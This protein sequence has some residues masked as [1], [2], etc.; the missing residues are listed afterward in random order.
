MLLGTATTNLFAQDRAAPSADPTAVTLTRIDSPIVIDGVVDEAAW[1]NVEPFDVVMY[2]PT[3]EGD[4][5]E[6]TEI[7]VAYDNDYV[8]VSGKLFDSEPDGVRSYSL[9]RDRYSGDDTFAIIL[10]TFNDNENA[11]WFYT[12]PEGVRFDMAVSSDANFGGGGRP[13]NSSWNT[14]WDASTS[15]HDRGWSA[16]MRIPFSSLGFQ[17]IGGEVT[18]GLI[19]YRFIA[20]KNERHIFPPIPPNWGLGFAKPS[21]AQDVVLRDVVAQRPV[22]ITPYVAGGADRRAQ[23]TD[24][25]TAYEHV[26]TFEREVGLDVKYNINSTLTLDVTVNTDFA[27]VE[28]DDQQVNLT[29]FSLFFPEKRQFFQERAGIFEFSLGGRDRL[30][31][32]RRI[33][34]A[35]GDLVRILGGARLVGRVGRWDLGIINMQT[36]R[37]SELDL[38][39]ENFGV[40]RARRQVVNENSY[41]GG[42]LTSRVDSDGMYNLGYGIDG[43]LRA[44]GDDYL[45][46]QVAQS[47]DRDQRDSGAFDLLDATQA[48][49]VWERRTEDGLWYDFTLKNVGKTFDPGVGFNTRTGVT[50]PFVFFG[51]GKLASD[52][53][54]V[55]R[56]S[57]SAGSMA[58]FRHEDGEMDSG[59]IEAGLEVDMKSG[60]NFEFEGVTA[61]ENLDDSLSFSDD[62]VVPPGDYTFTSAELSYRTARSSVL[63]FRTAVRGGGF[64]DGSRYSL[65]LSPTWALSKHLE[66]EAD[67]E[68][69]VIRFDDRDQDFTF[70][71]F[72]V[73]AQFALNKQL[74]SDVFLQYN[75]A[76]NFAT[77]NLRFRYNFREGNDLWLVVTEGTNRNR[78]RQLPELPISSS[79]AFIVKYTHTFGA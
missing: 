61:Y 3:F 1:D 4:M 70:H 22:Y 40:L 43:V 54:P 46:V 8:Y 29:R 37:T 47:V 68:V 78:M 34:V 74:S 38:P 24:A 57:P 58:W 79:R 15:K 36:A 28:A 6:D 63:R 39:S 64:F 18:M 26:N 67:W 17:N 45:T 5:S 76:A 71:L 9:Y 13:M 7:R 35:D 69:N 20:R 33:G 32:S 25:E 41:I 27:Q 72:G 48:R 2:Q 10:D 44:F 53:S 23:L 12:T 21:V 60:A 66:L 77:T 16:E 62:A 31:H 30:F 52:S 50:A 49:I 65:S 59:Q 56:F 42:M 14:F 75:T 51:Y 55:Q 73:K 11:L 19:V